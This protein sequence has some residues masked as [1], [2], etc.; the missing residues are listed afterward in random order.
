[1]FS[2][3]ICRLP[4]RVVPTKMI[5]PGTTLE[6]YDMSAIYTWDIFATLDGYGSYNEHGD[7]GGYWGKQ[8]P[9]LLEHRLALYNT[10]Q[11]MV[12]GADTF[13]E[14][15]AMVGPNTEGRDQVDP[16]VDRM[17]SM[18][19]TVVSSTLEGPFDWPA[20]TSGTRA[21]GGD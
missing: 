4:V 21:A 16:W 17:R 9:E 12:F 8:G 7:W 2:P 15:L 20:G 10:E 11:R 6:E 1:M 3:V 19:T 18:A 13:R 14:Q 5:P